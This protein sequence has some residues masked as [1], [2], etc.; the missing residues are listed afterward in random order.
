MLHAYVIVLYAWISILRLLG[1]KKYLNNRVT[2]LLTL[3]YTRGHPILR[4]L[5]FQNYFNNSAARQRIFLIGP[6]ISLLLGFKNYLNDS[7]ARLRNSFNCV[8]LVSPCR[9]GLKV[10]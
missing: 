1:F 10:I 6:Y 9:L 5:G 3:F 7:F 8:D 4:L 2:S